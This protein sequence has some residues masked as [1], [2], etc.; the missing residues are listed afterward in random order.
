MRIRSIVIACLIPVAVFVCDRLVFDQLLFSLP[1]PSGWDSF[2]WYNFES[3]F[4]SVER[5]RRDDKKPLVLAVGSSIAQYSILPQDFARHLGGRYNVELISHAAMMPTDLWNYRKRLMALKP[6]VIVWTTNP[7][8]LDLERLTPPWEAGPFRSRVTEDLFMS[9]RLPGRLYYPSSFV[10]QGVGAELT[11]AFA[12]KHMLYSSR[13]PRD[14]WLPFVQF[15]LEWRGPLKSYLNYQGV[16]IEGGVFREGFTGACFALSKDLTGGEMWMEVPSALFNAGVRLI[17]R[18]KRRALSSCETFSGTEI[19]PSRAGW[20]KIALPSGDLEIVLT[21]VMHE[22]E[23]AAVKNG[24]A[25]QGKGVRLPG[26][27]GRTEFAHDEVYLRR[28]SLEEAR[29][30]AL[31]ESELISDFENRMNPPDWRAHPGLANMGSMRLARHIAAYE[32]F[33]E[34]RA[35]EDLRRFVTD[36]SRDTRV[37]I[38]SQAEHPL[39]LDEYAWSDFYTGYGKFL[40]SLESSRVMVLDLHDALGMRDLGDP[41]HLTFGGARRVQPQMA[42]AVLRLLAR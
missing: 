32:G 29:F 23:A 21:H 16:P 40:R 26:N 13:F 5:R 42:D 39:S 36:V 7:A 11:A 20:Q 38:V 30:D 8:D 2:R 33:Q 10:G 35:M 25:F 9:H 3:V 18:E 28:P 6:D 17:V 19:V 31:P 22:G 15:A 24:P 27:L 34:N 1:N 41:H 4:R 14:E 12:M 37:L